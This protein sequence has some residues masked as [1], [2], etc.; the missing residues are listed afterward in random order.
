MKV[1]VE[2]CSVPLL[3]L[4]P[5][6][7]NWAQVTSYLLGGDYCMSGTEDPELIETWSL[8]LKRLS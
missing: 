3:S 6:R 5:Y 1:Q 2:S 7:R 4:L 8:P